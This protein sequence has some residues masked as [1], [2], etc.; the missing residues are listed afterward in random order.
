MGLF[1]TKTVIA[2]ISSVLVASAAIFADAV[3]DK[4]LDDNQNDFEYY[5][6]YFDDNAGMGN[7]DRP[8]AAPETQASV[9]NVEATEK[10]REFKGDKNDTYKV[11]E[12]KF[13]RKTE[14]SNSYAI[15][16][17]TFGE[18]FETP[19]GWDMNPF[20]GVGTMLAADGDYIDLTGVEKVKFKIR[21]AG[22]DLTVRF[23]VQTYEID[24]ISNGNADELE[25]EDNN[26]FGYYG[27]WDITATAGESFTEVEV[28]ISGGTNGQG[29]LTA[30]AW[31]KK[32]LD[33]NLKR[34]T[35]L[36]WEVNFEDNST[37]ESDTLF[38]DDIEFIGDYTFVSPFL[39]T[40]TASMTVPS[41]AAQ[42][43]TF[44]KK[45]FNQ[46]PLPMPLTN[47]W[48]AYDDGAI[49]GN[50]V[51]DGGAIK[52]EKTGL[53]D[54]D[55]QDGSG[56]DETGKA[57]LLQ[58][59]LGKPIQKETIE[60]KSFVGFGCNVY[61]SSTNKY[62]DGVASK[63]DKIYFQYATDGDVPYITFEVS[64]TFEVADEQHPDR[65]DGR[66]DGVVWFR[67][68]PATAGKWVAVEF[69]L[70]S[71][72]LHKDWEGAKNVPLVKT[73]LAKLQ[74]KVQGAESKSGTFA[75]DNV[76]FPG[77]EWEGVPVVRKNTVMQK[78]A[79]T[80]V[81]MNGN[82]NVTV[83]KVLTNGTVSL[84]S[85]NGTRIATKPVGF[86]TTF[87]A[88]TLPAGMYLVKISAVDAHG[89]AVSMQSPVTLVK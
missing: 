36:A 79:F 67:N 49:K 2:G 77:A 52:N 51:V 18:V 68:F 57:M 47:Y 8:Q 3:V 76:Y 56:S 50:A 12:Y 84:F 81:N 63:V 14:G 46:T 4:A 80:A 13:T 43:A 32:A 6:Y 78:A 62:W 60:I 24:S 45:P 58:F 16:P 65:K 26:P 37:V 88:K 74:W 19:E 42:F 59:T 86:K 41:G 69:P 71:L 21:S 7:N 27:K 40:K 48:Y 73:H 23:K 17:F 1:K 11:K 35:K 10:N 53:L 15:M 89:K 20:V 72:K 25:A 85:S 55:F 83:G 34:A 64:D 70:D 44:D 9:I 33:Y 66:G 54:L 5:W 31:A 87:S 30:P 75:V 38:I 82:I 29:D 22:K 28:A 61:D 39:W